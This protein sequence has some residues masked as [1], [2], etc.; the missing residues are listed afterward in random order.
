M[1]YLKIGLAV[2]ALTMSISSFAAD[3]TSYEI[4]VATQINGLTTK[5]AS[6]QFS[7][8]N[9]N[10]SISTSKTPVKFYDPTFPEDFNG[11]LYQIKSTINGKTSIL[12]ENL[13]DKTKFQELSQKTTKPDTYRIFIGVFYDTKTS[14]YVLLDRFYSALISLDKVFPN[15]FRTNENKTVSVRLP[16]GSICNKDNCSS[17]LNLDGMG[18][19]TDFGSVTIKNNSQ[20][21]LYITYYNI[22]KPSPLSKEKYTDDIIQ[23]ETEMKD[24]TATGMSLDL[25]M[26]KNE[27]S[28]K[29]DPAT[30]VKGNKEQKYQTSN[31]PTQTT[32]FMSIKTSGD[33]DNKGQA[34]FLQVPQAVIGTSTCTYN[35]DQTG[36]NLTV[37]PAAGS[38]CNVL[39]LSTLDLPT[40]A[41]VN[42]T[43]KNNTPNI[44]LKA[45]EVDRCD[46][47]PTETPA[48]ANTINPGKSYTAKPSK[49]Y[50]AV[51]AVLDLPQG[52]KDTV[53]GCLSTTFNKPASEVAGNQVANVSLTSDKWWFDLNLP[54]GKDKGMKWGPT[55]AAPTEKPGED[56]AMMGDI[57][58][59][60]QE[61]DAGKP[62]GVKMMLKTKDAPDGQNYNISIYKDKDLTTL[63]NFTNYESYPS[64]ENT[65]S[66]NM[67]VNGPTP[68]LEL[69]T[70]GNT[71]YSVVVCERATHNRNGCNN[72]DAS[73]HPKFYIKVNANR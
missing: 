39:G 6:L 72:A 36:D 57:V 50:W 12:N 4:T 31:S 30:Q 10:G 66:K 1:K 55:K 25:Q 24:S 47:L 53:I 20:Y 46:T 63:A 58:K 17:E 65:N 19:P 61:K 37:S 71:V 70:P 26:D 40:A 2:T 45:F 51:A 67:I 3:P 29:P 41:D 9:S 44:T 49:A 33:E 34:V 60:L 11:N 73:A 62:T 64:D 14:K 23:F 32:V 54:N 52:G 8:Y 18:L 48:D 5:T 22:N 28:L 68:E 15:T 69:N 59:A 27:L 13:L 42:N 21:P 43:I 38:R 56:A 35:V 7:K 16:G